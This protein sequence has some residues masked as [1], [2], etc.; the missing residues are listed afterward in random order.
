M[1]DASS[2]S[3]DRSESLPPWASLRYRDYRFLFLLALFATSAQQM[4]QAQ[5]LYQVYELSGSAFLLGH[6]R[7][8]PGS[9]DFRSRLV[10]R[11]AR[12]LSRS[13]ENSSDHDLRESSRRDHSGLPD[14]RRADSGLA[15]SR[16]HSAHLG[17]QHRAQPDAHGAHL[18]PC[19]ALALD[20]RRGAQ[21]QRFARRPIS[22]GPC[23][24]V[25]AWRG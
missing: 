12:G 1:S 21:L 25:S 22:S 8:R 23:S 14:S 3:T 4:R 17:A 9:A 15:Y 5:N 2:G 11:H 24:A 7:S 18:P 16:R 13:Q 10:R 20:Q 19:A 6:D